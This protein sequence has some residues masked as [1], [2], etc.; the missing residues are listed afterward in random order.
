MKSNSFPAFL[1]QLAV[2]AA[3][4]YGVLYVI[5]TRVY[6]LPAMPNEFMVGLMFAVTAISHYV[7]IKAGEKSNKNFTYT[8]MLSSIIRLTIYAIFMVWFGRKHRDILIEF[9][10]CFFGLYFVFMIFEVRSVLGYMKNSPPN[11]PQGKV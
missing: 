10:A 6:Q 9:V 2:I 8:F 3:L 7:L 4:A 11:P 1:I 5:C